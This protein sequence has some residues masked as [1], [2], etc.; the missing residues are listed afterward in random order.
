MITLPTNITANYLL[1]GNKPR[2]LVSIPDL[3]LS[4][5]TDIE[6][7]G[8]ITRSIPAF[9][10]LERV[11]RYSVRSLE[12][13]DELT[14]CTEPV[15]IVG[16]SEVVG[17]QPARGCGRILSESEGDGTYL[18]ARDATAG[19]SFDWPA[20]VCG[21]RLYSLAGYDYYS[22][23]RPYLQ[24]DIPAGMTSLEEATLWLAG[25]SC[26]GTFTLVIVAG[27]YA[28]LQP[29]TGLLND[30]TGWAA[31]GA[32]GVTALNESWASAEF[33]TYS[34]AVTENERYNLIRFNTAGLAAILAKTGSTIRLMMLSSKDIAGTAPTGDEYAQFETGATATLRLRYNTLDLNNRQVKSYFYYPNADGSTPAT[35]AMLERYRGVVDRYAITDRT[36]DLDI[37]AS[38]LKQ[39]VMIPTKLIEDTTWTDCPESNIGRPYPIVIGDFTTADADLL[40]KDGI[41]YTV[42]TGS[43]DFPSY[44]YGYTDNFL[45]GL[46]VKKAFPKTIL[47]SQYGMVISL[48]PP[49]I[50]NGQREIFDMLT[51]GM[52][53]IAATDEEVT[54]SLTA[55]HGTWPGVSRPWPNNYGRLSAVKPVSCSDASANLVTPEEAYSDNPATYAALTN[56]AYLDV[57]FDDQANMTIPERIY[58]AAQLAFSGGATTFRI[59]YAY[60]SDGVTWNNFVYNPTGKDSPTFEDIINSAYTVGSYFFACAI[61]NVFR[62]TALSQLRVR[63]A[64]KNT[65]GQ[66]NVKNVALMISQGV[67]EF[68]SVALPGKGLPFGTWIDAAGRTDNGDATDLIESPPYVIEGLAR[69]CIPLA[70]AAIDTAGIDAAGTELALWKHAFQILD[71]QRISQILDRIGI[72]SR[73][74]VYR[75][76]LDRLTMRTW[77]ATRAFANSGTDIPGDLDIFQETS[78]AAVAAGVESMTRNPIMGGFVLDEV[79]ADQVY[80]SFV[81]RF[82]ENYASGDFLEVLTMDNGGGVV[83]SVVTNLVAGDAANM[84]DSQTIAGLKALCAASYTANQSLT[85]QMVFES[86]HIRVR[87][88]AVKLL[89]HLIQAYTRRLHICEFTT[90]ENAL[91]AEYYDMINIRHTRVYELFGIPTAQRKKWAII[92]TAHDQSAGTITITAI[93]ARGV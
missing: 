67:D 92:G 55:P 2:V 93:E 48:K 47:L 37:K 43:S 33:V 45:L 86:R 36:L 73:T 22:V 83:G 11:S 61:E 51:A 19:T 40:H 77:D 52:H 16:R 76:E 41:A 69:A 34:A 21:Q 74:G 65:T 71:Q 91:W 5:T 29:A 24:F 9:G 6:N 31:S 38:D 3:G 57:F 25:I 84:E 59:S 90:R 85:N 26:T 14:F 78:D 68:D 54:K 63:F 53:D 49:V 81:L 64:M 30:F 39:D 88:T 82:R 70:T 17:A 35:S 62:V 15:P 42:G 79:D 87:A 72:E 75:D 56:N 8:T 13:A 10:G 66:V 50:W 44:Q 7:A 23:A 18:S 32:Y 4:L 89:Q 20:V 12:L 58:L 1:T 60:T 27:S 46:V 80:N 28:N